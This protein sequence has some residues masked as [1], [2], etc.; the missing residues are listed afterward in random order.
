MISISVSSRGAR[1]V[2]ISVKSTSLE[3][4]SPAFLSECVCVCVQFPVAYIEE[5]KGRWWQELGRSLSEWF[6]R[7]VWGLQAH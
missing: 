1:L 3:P 7:N 5:N 2:N 4:Q 6:W